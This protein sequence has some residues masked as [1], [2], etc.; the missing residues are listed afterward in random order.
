MKENPLSTK[1]KEAIQ[2]QLEVD[3]KERGKNSKDQTEEFEKYK[4]QK[5][6]EKRKQKHKGK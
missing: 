2:K 3:K 1:S 6:I 4:W 5:A